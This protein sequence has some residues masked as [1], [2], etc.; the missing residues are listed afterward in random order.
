[1]RTKSKAGRTQP[2]DGFDKLEQPALKAKAVRFL[3]AR[4]Y[5]RAELARKLG[6]LAQHPDD[7]DAVLDDLARQGWQSDARVAQSLQRVK[8]A[9][10]GSAMIAQAMRQKGLS[11][12]LVAQ[13]LDALAATELERARTV[14]QKKFG[15][16]GL[17][18]DLKEKARQMR[19]LASRGF[20]G[21]VVRRVL[22]GDLDVDLDGD[23][24]VDD[25]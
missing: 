11:D 13:T 22:G 14:W 3:A 17:A 4:E 16:V 25:D 15:R 5:T 24:D 1:M 21:D 23:F 10:Q 19:F 6:P 12:E 18:Q 8:A 9:K 2:S 7:I 20:G